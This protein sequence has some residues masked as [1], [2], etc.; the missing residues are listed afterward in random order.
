MSSFWRRG[1]PTSATKDDPKKWE[2]SGRP[3]YVRQACDA[4]LKRLGI[5]TI[6]LYNQHRVAP[7]T[8]IED[9]VGAMAELVKAGKVRYLG[10]SEASPATIRRGAQGPPDYGARDRVLAVG[11]AR[12]GPDSAYRSR[13]RDRFWALQPVGK[14]IS[15]GCDCQTGRFGQLRFPLPTIS[16]I[17]R[18]ELRPESGAGSPDPGDCGAAGGQ[19]GATRFGVGAG[20]RRGPGADSG[21]QAA[22]VSRGERCGCRHSG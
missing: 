10:L 18:R 2:I 21:D 17:C 15:D 7:E 9:T 14:R 11:A 5:D 16:A 6:D 8:P 20:A 22:E 1:L 4:S 13:T 12:G 19:A 3:E